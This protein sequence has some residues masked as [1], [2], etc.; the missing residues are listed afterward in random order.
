MKGLSNGTGRMYFMTE[1][2]LFIFLLCLALLNYLTRMARNFSCRARVCS[3]SGLTSIPKLIFDNN[4]SFEE[5]FHKAYIS[6]ECDINQGVNRIF[7]KKH[8]AILSRKVGYPE[9]VFKT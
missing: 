8:F 1:L 2:L 7:Y 3:K 6:S 4:F 5:S 9:T